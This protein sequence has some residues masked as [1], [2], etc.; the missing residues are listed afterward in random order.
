[1]ALVAT[2]FRLLVITSPVVTAIVVSATMSVV[3]AAVTSG[4]RQ[5][6]GRAECPLELLALKNG[7]GASF[8]EV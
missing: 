7:V 4:S 5:V 6:F 8:M 2:V 1:V 3:A